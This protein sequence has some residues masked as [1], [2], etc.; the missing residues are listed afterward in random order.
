[1]TNNDG[2]RDEDM[3]KGEIMTRGAAIRLS[4]KRQG[5]AMQDLDGLEDIWILGE[6]FFRDVK[7][8]FDVSLKIVPFS[9]FDR[10][11]LRF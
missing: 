11:R 8:M 7:V 2:D 4:E 6:P 9:F 10:A 3:G 5:T 1:M